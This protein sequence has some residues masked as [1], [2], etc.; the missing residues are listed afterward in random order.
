VNFS[1]WETWF[2]RFQEEKRKCK[3][4]SRLFT[5]RMDL[6]WYVISYMCM[7]LYFFMYSKLGVLFLKMYIVF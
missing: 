7:I 5:Y 3:C 2:M 4:N 6:K 1:A